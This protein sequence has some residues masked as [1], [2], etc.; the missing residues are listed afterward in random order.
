[1]VDIAI[2]AA[3]IVLLQLILI[4]LLLYWGFSLTSHAL[5]RNPEYSF[6]QIN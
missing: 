2:F 3:I 1:M 6:L 4:K 5:L